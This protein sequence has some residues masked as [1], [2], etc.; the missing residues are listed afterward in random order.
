M[1]DLILILKRLGES[2]FPTEP[3]AGDMLRAVRI[4][5]AVGSRALVF[6]TI[7]CFDLGTAFP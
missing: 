4:V 6:S 3:N 7:S 2:A 1:V 5:R